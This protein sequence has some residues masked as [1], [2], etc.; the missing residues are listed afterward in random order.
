MASSLIHCSHPAHSLARIQSPSGVYTCDLC[1]TWG[2]GLH[3][4]CDA[5]DFDLHE[6]CAEF[7]E[8]ISFFAHPWHDL[9]LKPDTGYR[10]CDLCREPVKGF[11]Y[12]CIPCN[13][14]VHP[15]CT[16][17]QQIVR[18]ELHPEH[19]L[20]LVPSLNECSAC[21]LFNGHIWLYRCG[22][23]SVNLHI[24][25]V[26]RILPMEHNNDN[27]TRSSN[28]NRSSTGIPSHF[29]REIGTEVVVAAT[30]DVLTQ[31]VLQLLS[32]FFYFTVKTFQKNTLFLILFLFLGRMSQCFWS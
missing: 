6:H 5:C 25:C 4:R 31:F 23:C 7:P 32:F 22:M 1:E 26:G 28:T 9:H 13:F 10:I 11:Y 20:C 8:T 17:I 19:N 16:K 3:Y 27:R 12:R 2:S 18:T 14:D 21:K 29:W 24:R 15:H 30:A